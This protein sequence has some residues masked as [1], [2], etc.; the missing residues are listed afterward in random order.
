LDI[1]QQVGV[2]R[3]LGVLGD[4]GVIGDET[5]GESSLEAGRS[6][7]LGVLLA[8]RGRRGNTDL[9]NA[10]VGMRNTAGASGVAGQASPVALRQE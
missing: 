10:G 2:G 4:G 8:G 6:L 7:A 1:S 5:V 9:W 3:R